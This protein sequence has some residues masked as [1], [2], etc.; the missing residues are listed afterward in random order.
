MDSKKIIWPSLV[1]Q[2][3]RVEFFLKEV[4]ERDEIVNVLTSVSKTNDI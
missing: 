1:N 2:V 3:N 4:Y